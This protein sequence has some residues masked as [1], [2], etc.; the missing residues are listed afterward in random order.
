MDATF[1][2]SHAADASSELGPVLTR[3]L[4]GHAGDVF[5]EVRPPSGAGHVLSEAGS[6]KQHGQ[7]QHRSK[8]SLSHVF[9]LKT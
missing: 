4:G 2:S 6:E 1:P 9:Y 8:N 3:M 5:A 7:Y